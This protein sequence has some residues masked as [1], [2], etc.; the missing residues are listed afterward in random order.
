MPSAP[1]PSA[2]APPPSPTRLAGST[3]CSATTIRPWRCSRQRP[4]SAANDPT[5]QLHAARAFQAAGRPEP[6]RQF[7]DRAIALD[8]G[9]AIGA[10][11][12][13]AQGGAEVDPDAPGA[14]QD[15]TRPQRAAAGP[16]RPK[17]HIGAV[18]IPRRQEHLPKLYHRENRDARQRDRGE[19]NGTAGP[20][21]GRRQ[22]QG[23]QHADGN[24][25]QDFRQ[26]FAQRIEWV[27]PVVIPER[28]VEQ[29]RDTLAEHV[30]GDHEIERRPVTRQDDG[31]ARAPGRP[32][33]RA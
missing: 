18:R 33:A 30:S 17:Q 22:E 23:Q 6:A 19:N 1:I 5:I 14:R 16:Q 25:Q 7:L 31:R 3:I 8:P 13:G 29:G 20:R 27:R 24:A 10:G 32:A 12:P 26:R 2:G 21:A 11:G 9:L 4:R 15:E 28:D